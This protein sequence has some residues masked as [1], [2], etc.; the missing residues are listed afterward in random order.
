[1][2]YI[3]YAIL[4][5]LAV[6]LITVALANSAAVTFHLLPEGL[7]GFLGLSWQVTLP[8]FIVVFLG[9]ILGILVG[10]VWEWARESKHRAEG[11]RAKKAAVNLAR[12][13][14]SLKATDSAAPKDEVLALLDEK[15]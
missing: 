12:E 6:V 2:R 13:V 1:M 7:S 11:K 3:R 4:A 14:K 9:V 10:F 15:S 5:I 8:L